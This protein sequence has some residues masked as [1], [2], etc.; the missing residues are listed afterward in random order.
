MEDAL[1]I[2]V[3]EEA[4]EKNHTTHSRCGEVGWD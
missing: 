4:V 3:V 1:E 2:E